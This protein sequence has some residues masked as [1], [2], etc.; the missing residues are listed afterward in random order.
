MFC[1]SASQASAE[2]RGKVFGV[3]P[4]MTIQSSYFGLEF[5]RLQ[6]FIGLDWVGVAVTSDDNDVS[7]S[8]F[9]PHLG[10]KLFLSNYGV[11]HTVA[12]YF[13]GD[14]FFST[15]SVNADQATGAVENAVKDVLEFWGLGFGFGA[16]YFFSE[17]FSVGGEYGVRYLHDKVDEHS[18]TYEYSPGYPSVQKVNNE[19]TLAFKVTYAVL[20]VNYHFG[21]K[22]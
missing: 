14:W 17:S 10:T 19:F 5:T 3:K 20:S 11:E 7:A 6:P 22:K 18:D 16:E 21:K 13:L 8:V 12:P 1:L 4:G 2:L 9:I 15:A